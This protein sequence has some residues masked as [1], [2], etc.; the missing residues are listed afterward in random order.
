MS[1]RQ[2]Q[3]ATATKATTTIETMADIERGCRSLRRRCS[4]MRAIYAVAGTPALRRRPDG[5]EG[6]ARI[7]VGQQLS[8]A[9]ADA[10]WGRLS[11]AIRPFTPTSLATAAD[12]QLRAAGLSRPKIKTLR[13]AAA[14]AQDGALCFATLKNAGIEDIHQQLTA[15]PGIGP[16]TADIY[17]MFCLGARD[18]FA[19]GDLALQEAVR[20]SFQ[21]ERR[22]SPSELLEY[23]EAWRPWR[24]VAARLL[25]AYY[26]KSRSGTI[27]TANRRAPQNAST[28]A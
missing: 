25:W 11:G 14:A 17:A 21:L 18:A 12:A 9:S 27:A 4:Q 5:F 26:A 3:S 1:P 15:L 10:I 20:I 13:A 23:A 16:W 22:P 6:L 7:V 24:G 28:R 19:S 8:I 2:Q